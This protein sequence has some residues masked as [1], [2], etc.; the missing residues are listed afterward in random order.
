MIGWAEEAKAPCL[1]LIEGRKLTDRSEAA[2]R[3]I[4]TSCNSTEILATLGHVL[5]LAWLHASR[6]LVMAMQPLTGLEAG[7]PFFLSTLFFWG[8]C[9]GRRYTEPRHQR[10]HVCIVGSKG[11]MVCRWCAHN[12]YPNRGDSRRKQS[13][14]PREVQ[15]LSLHWGG[16]DLRSS[17]MQGSPSKASQLSP[18]RLGWGAGC[19]ASSRHTSCGRSVGASMGRIRGDTLC[20][21]RS[22]CTKKLDS[23]SGQFVRTKWT[24]M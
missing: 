15:T 3:I 8:V 4:D 20:L 21:F 2:S 13:P 10:Q 14:G 17:L 1:V 22:R 16:G 11:S 7:L 18:S 24:F 9:W 5:Y 19:S 12:T 23:T 6:V